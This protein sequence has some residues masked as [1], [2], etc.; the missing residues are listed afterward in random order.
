MVRPFR[1]NCSKGR[2]G[3]LA[4]IELREIHAIMMAVCVKGAASASASSGG[5]KR[6][7]RWN[8]P[9]RMAPDLELCEKLNDEEISRLPEIAKLEFQS[10]YL[11]L[12]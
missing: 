10:W 2:S 6:G 4:R 8:R 12:E 1:Q 7:R 9:C 3:E 5:S 11:V